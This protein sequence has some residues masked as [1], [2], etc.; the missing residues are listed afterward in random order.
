MDEVFDIATTKDSSFVGGIG[1]MVAWKFLRRRGIWAHRIGGWYPFPSNF[2]FIRGKP[3]YELRGLKT[4][5]VEYLKEMCLHGPR[6]YDFVG[7][8][9]KKG[10]HG[11]AGDIEDVYLVEVKTEGVRSSRHDLQ[12]LMKGK[13]PNDVDRPKELGFKVLFVL[14]SLIDDWKCNISCN[15][16]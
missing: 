9:R 2:P 5:Q 6:R 10:P 7:V 4:E 1:E 13:I 11:L 3:S 14:V 8:K 12:G 16:L 15:E